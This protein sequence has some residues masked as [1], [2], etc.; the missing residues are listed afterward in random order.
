[1]EQVINLKRAFEFD[2]KLCVF[3]QKRNATKDD[4]RQST[5]YSRSVVQEAMKM[6]SK[7]RDVDN[8]DTNSRLECFIE[9]K[10]GAFSIVLHRECDSLFTNKQ[11]ID[12]LQKKFVEIG[13][14]MEPHVSSPCKTRS[15][16]DKT[17]WELCVF[18]ENQTSKE[19]LSS[20]MTFG[21]NDQIYDIARYN[22]K[23]GIRLADVS[24]SITSEA[25][26]HLACF[27]R[28][29]RSV[30]NARKAAKDTDLAMVW[31]CQE[32]E[33]AAEKGHVIKMSDA[34][35]RYTFLAEKAGVKIPTSCK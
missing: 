8:I 17:N 1:M 6:R 14:S 22:Y 26:Y 31:L 13:K 9:T 35:S 33:N 21:M 25:K 19:R 18:C 34:W 28:F 32:L 10:D 23:L 29:K 27:S 5:A 12:R 11:K 30:E 15:H 7:L 3:S 4:V 20:V 24:D 2:S 16:V